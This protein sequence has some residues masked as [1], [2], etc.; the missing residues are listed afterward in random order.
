MILHGGEIA[1]H[2][3]GAGGV[4]LTLSCHRHCHVMPAVK[5]QKDQRRT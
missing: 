1:L 2:T 5:L 3:D 4:E